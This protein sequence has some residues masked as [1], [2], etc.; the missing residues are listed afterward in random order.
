MGIFAGYG[1]VIEVDYPLE[2]AFD[3]GIFSYRSAA[4]LPI[5]PH[6]EN[7]ISDSKYF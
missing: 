3:G 2:D 4:T 6:L 1:S 7:T 5:S